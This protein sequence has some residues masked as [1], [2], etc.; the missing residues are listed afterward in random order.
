MSRRLALVLVL[1]LVLGPGAGCG[2]HPHRSMGTEID[3]RGEA[4][5]RA[6]L[7]LPAEYR[8]LTIG[9]VSLLAAKEAAEDES[10]LEVDPDALRIAL[11]DL[12]AES[13]AFD[14][15]ALLEDRAA[16][17][18]DPGLRLEAQMGGALLRR[19]PD[20]ESGFGN[21]LAWFFGGWL[22]DWHHDRV[23]EMR[24]DPLI[25]L[26]D[27]RSEQALAACGPVS[28]TA[29]DDLSL[30]ERRDGAGPVIATVLW[31]P[32][33]AF[34][35]RPKEVTRALAPA[36]LG[37]PVRELLADLAD[38]KVT[39]RVET[40]ALEQRPGIRVEVLSPEQGRLLATETADVQ[41]QVTVRPEV[42][43]LR[44]L[45]VGGCEV[46]A[47]GASVDVVV[48]GVPL[49]PGKPA[50]VKVELEKGAPLALLEISVR[51]EV[52]KAPPAGR[53]K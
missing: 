31:I 10:A 20:E 24:L 36:C 42:G 39:Y 2:A 16:G 34:D 40:R 41:R 5:Q 3:W 6:K 45:I 14:D 25:T 33:F 4:P 27:P 49:A 7:D 12:L 51:R 48:P 44:K 9:R 30:H 37:P 28:A 38:L 52:K 26:V 50:E 21:F 11:R 8:R 29:R 46:A 19:L 35:S 23:F 43:R 53:G 22:G 17:A 18:P 32:Q 1:V 47:S 15:V 13:G